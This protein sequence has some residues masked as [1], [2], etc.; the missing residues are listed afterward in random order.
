L[1]ERIREGNR[2]M[3]ERKRMEKQQDYGPGKVRTRKEGRKG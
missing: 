1:D 2:G 3:G